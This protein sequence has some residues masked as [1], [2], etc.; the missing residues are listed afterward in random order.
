[1][2]EQILRT[3]EV[4]STYHFFAV[5]VFVINF[6]WSLVRLWKLVFLSPIFGVIAAA[7]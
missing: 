4:C 2:E 7:W 5:P 3:Q 6:V 1:M